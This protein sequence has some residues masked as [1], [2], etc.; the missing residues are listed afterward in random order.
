LI[1]VTGVH[2]CVARFGEQ[3]LAD[4]RILGAGGRDFVDETRDCMQQIGARDDAEH[5]LIFD[6]R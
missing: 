1:G 5:L 3:A 6:N 2:G 4:C